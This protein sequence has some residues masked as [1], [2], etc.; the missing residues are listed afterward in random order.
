V[1]VTSSTSPAVI[2]RRRFD[3][4]RLRHS[5][6][7]GL[8]QAAQARC[9]EVETQVGLAKARLLLSDDVNAMLEA[10]QARVHERS[11][12]VFE[13]LLSAILQDVLPEKG[14]VKLELATER[15]LPALDVLIDNAGSKEDALEGSGGAVT[16]VLVTGLRFAALSRTTNRKL[17]VL[18]EPDCWLKPERVPAFIRVIAQVAEQA[19]TQTLL[20]SHHDPALFE[21]QVNL[22]KLQRGAQGPSAQVIEPRLS[23]WG[24]DSTT[25]GIRSIRLVNFRAHQDTLIPVFPGVTALVG[26][27]DVGK[28]TAVVSAL[29]AVA[30]NESDDTVIRHGEQEAQIIIELEAGRKIVW[31]RKLKGSPKVL[32]ALYE[33]DAL[34]QEGRPA[35]R[36]AVPEWVSS[37]LGIARVDDLDI[38]L[39]SQKEP[40][41]LLNESPSTRA[42]L[43]SVGRESGR[44]HQLIEK[45]GD[46][47][48]KD[49]EV[50]RE[51]EAELVRLRYRIES[52]AL[53]SACSARLETQQEKAIELERTSQELEKLEKLA[54][55]TQQLAVRL[56]RLRPLLA[57][58]TQLPMPPVLEDTH[59]LARLI[60]AVDRAARVLKTPRPGEVPVI[61]EL[62]NTQLLA[63][64]GVRLSRAQRQLLAVT[65]A[66]SSRLPEAP[67]L[68]DGSGLLRQLAKIETLKTSVQSSEVA[69]RDASIE[70]KDAQAALL[71]LRDELGASCPLCGG[72]LDDEALL[73]HSHSEVQQ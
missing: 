62:A 45:Y 59:D 73:Q 16:N 31:S 8:R 28:S 34:A 6:M 38:Q 40:V 53:L 1:A 36:S 72:F 54:Q 7:E 33:G 65:S 22:V 9:A 60:G 61:P 17:V 4:L 50:S 15:G 47:K 5:K 49:R 37:V 3:D 25:P 20:V 55:K 42:Q 67:V 66:V 2:L 51:G 19:N 52:S 70:S 57:S 68:E 24:E 26:D 58:Y 21:G 10:L 41:F 69:A 13:R 63:E 12:G 29:R 56:E 32:Y 64:L 43:L 39:A 48:R 46:L 23:A 71:K 18:D 14:N 11:V 44:L 35:G 30:Y 27:N